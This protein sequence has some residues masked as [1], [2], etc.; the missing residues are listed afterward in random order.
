MLDQVAYQ[1]KS[2]YLNLIQDTTS[3]QD[4][5]L[6][7]VCASRSITYQNLMKVRLLIIDQMFRFTHYQLVEFALFLINPFSVVIFLI[8]Y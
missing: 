5:S 7:Y 2:Q 6:F 4:S 8:F 1:A 3:I